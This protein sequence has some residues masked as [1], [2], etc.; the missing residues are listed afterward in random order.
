MAFSDW[1][2]SR[3]ATKPE[4]WSRV[5]NTSKTNRNPLVCDAWAH[6]YPNNDIITIIIMNFPTINSHILILKL[7]QHRIPT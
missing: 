7:Q 2:I 3:N 1:G 5:S 4:I 6:D